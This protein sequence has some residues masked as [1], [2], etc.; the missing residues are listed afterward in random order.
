[1]LLLKSCFPGRK[2]KKRLYLVIMV[3]HTNLRLTSEHPKG[4][5]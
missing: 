4:V 3:Y 2:K 5:V 1:M